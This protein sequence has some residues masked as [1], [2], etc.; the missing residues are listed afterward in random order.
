M[1]DLRLDNKKMNLGFNFINNEKLTHKDA[2][3]NMELLPNDE[4]L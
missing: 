4:M 1:V 3:Y 2:K